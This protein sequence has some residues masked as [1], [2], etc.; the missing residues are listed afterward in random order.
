MDAS[1]LRALQAPLKSK[2]LADPKSAIVTLKTSATLS[3]GISCK[4]S[5]GKA[6]QEAG[7]H[8]MAG[9]KGDQLY[10]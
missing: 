4:L 2:F 9:G 5:T 10:A 6:M 1:T 3:E 7:L 8:P